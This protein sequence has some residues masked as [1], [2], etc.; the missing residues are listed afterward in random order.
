MKIIITGGHLTPALA[1]IDFIQKNH[2]ADEIIFIGRKFSQKNGQLAQEETEL[3]KRN[4]KFVALETPKLATQQLSHLLANLPQLAIAVL[5][6][7]KI[8]K[9][10]NADVVLAFGSYLS[11]PV[12][13]AAKLANIPVVI[14]E[15]TS[16]L[17]LANKIISHF[18][19]KVALSQENQSYQNQAKFVFTGNP[20]R[21]TLTDK[22]IKPNWIKTNSH[23]PWLYITGGNQGS[24]IINQLV[25]EALL[26]LLENFV[27]IHQV[28]NPHQLRNYLAELN[29]KRQ[30]LPANLQADYYVRPWIEADELA[31]IMQHSDLALS[32]SG[33][34]T[35]QEFQYFAI[36]TLYIPLPNSRNNEQ[37]NN[38]KKIVETGGALLLQQSQVNSGKL[39]E[40]LKKLNAN[41]IKMKT[42]LQKNQLKSPL[43]A[44]QNI[45]QLLKSTQ[46]KK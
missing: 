11:V 8:I 32:R 26:P 33:A 24:A 5:K 27:V 22:T 20:L 31:W 41:K 6:S 42:Q 10:H 45:Y 1:C 36:P 9:S 30:T 25:G 39:L 23:K 28:G 40:A 34:N 18:A 14:H 29:L 19:G 35:V 15:Q 16:R 43:I 4:I 12:A 17:G 38:A 7:F 3:R 2:Q 46:S 37:L 21:A 44:A 13:I